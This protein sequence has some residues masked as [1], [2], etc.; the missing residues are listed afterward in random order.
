MPVPPAELNAHFRI[1][2]PDGAV[3][4]ARGAAEPSGLARDA[5]PGELLLTGPRDAVLGTLGDAVVAALD[6]GAW[7]L[8]VKLEAPQE[9]RR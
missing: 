3:D 5:G 2:G 9:S 7:A 1:G 6:A 8:D 4:A